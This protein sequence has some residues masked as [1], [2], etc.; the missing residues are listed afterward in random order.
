MAAPFSSVKRLAA[1]PL[2][3]GVVPAIT[4]VD[5]LF[6]QLGEF[7][8]GG[9]IAFDAA[10]DANLVVPIQQVLQVVLGKSKGRQKREGADDEEAHQDKMV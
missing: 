4:V 6:A 7:V 5:D 9:G 3:F 8:T 2:L 10:F 1:P